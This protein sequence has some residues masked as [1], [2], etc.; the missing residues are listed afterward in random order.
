MNQPRGMQTIFAHYG[1]NLLDMTKQLLDVSGVAGELPPGG[2]VAVKPNLV[3][4]RPADGGATTHP[5]I[6]AGIIEF[7][8]DHG[9]QDIAV[10]ESSWLGDDTG[11]AFANCGYVALAERYG[12]TLCDLKSDRAVPVATPAGEVLICEKALRADFL[13]NVPVLKGHCQTRMTCALKNLKGCIPDS[14][15]R[16]FHRED[17]HRLIAGLAVALRP[18]LTVVDGVCGDLDFEEGGTPVRADRILLG[19]DPFRIDVLGCRLLGFDPNEV[20]YL[21]LAAQWGL[22]DLSSEDWELVELARPNAVPAPRSEGKAARLGRAVQADRACSSCYAALIH[23]LKRFEEQ[24]GSAAKGAIHI[25]QGWKGKRLSGLGI[26][27]CCAG[28]ERHVPGCPPTAADIMAA[29]RAR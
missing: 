26:G 7:L 4:A 1:D 29:L 15:K 18:A 11:R 23:A 20:R 9:V 3:V 2:S 14:E 13:I 24:G 28:V 16:R 12:V 5:E 19:R 22:G 17:L 25:G 27:A 8:R 6:A 10:I 21:G